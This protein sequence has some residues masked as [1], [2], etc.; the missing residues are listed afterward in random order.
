[1][2]YNIK[3]CDLVLQRSIDSVSFYVDPSDDFNDTRTYPINSIRI[4]GKIGTD[5]DITG[6]SDWALLP[7]RDPECY[8]ELTVEQ[9]L[10][11]QVIR[12]IIFSKA[13]VISYAERYMNDSGI[14]YF[15][16]FVRQ[17]ANIDIECTNGQSAP[18]V[19][20]TST[21]QTAIV[22]AP[23]PQVTKLNHQ[24]ESMFEI[25]EGHAGRVD[26]FSMNPEYVKEDLM[27][28]EIGRKTQEYI[29]KNNVPVQLSYEKR[30]DKVDGKKVPIN[31]EFDPVL[32]VCKSYVLN[33]LMPDITAGN[34]VH[35]VFHYYIFN[36]P[37]G[38]F[39]GIKS[40]TKREE[41]IARCLQEMHLHNGKPPLKAIRR[42]YRIAYKSKGYSK[43]EDGRK[44]I[45]WKAKD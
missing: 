36:S 6:V 11:D 32:N 43:L 13:F 4:E 20:A 27:K 22:S 16:L 7:A 2:S 25:V 10:A 3:I 23:L 24:K 44:Y 35:E 8:K 19:P 17:M 12:K 38:S 18:A 21:T 14:G 15:S 37:E 45:P 29:L 33:T 1:M 41:F 9:T 26:W 30:V 40:Y 31:G 5:E 28:S 39:K 34:V 42:Q